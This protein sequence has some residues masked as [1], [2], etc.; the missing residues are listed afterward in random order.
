MNIIQRIIQ[1][2]AFPSFNI[3][4]LKGRT[5]ISE[6]SKELRYKVLQ[7]IF[8]ILV[9]EIDYEKM[10]QRVTDVMVEDMDFLGGVLF[11]FDKKQRE[12]IAW[13]YT[14]SRLGNIVVSWLPKSFREYRYPLD[15]K[16]NL[17]VDTFLKEKM[18]ITTRMADMISPIVSAKMSDKMQGFMGMKL[19]V[20]LPIKFHN[21]ML[22]VLFFTSVREE[23]SEEELK[24]LKTFT[25]QVAIAIQNARLFKKIQD[26]IKK[27]EINDKQQRIIFNI[28]NQLV[29]TL[30]FKEISQRAV[31]LIPRETGYFGAVLIGYDKENQLLE[32]ISRTTTSFDKQVVQII[33]ENFQDR[34]Q[35][36]ID[37]LTGK[38]TKVVESF[39]EDKIT[40]TDNFAKAFSPPLPVIMS[41][42]QQKLLNI[43]SVVSIPLKSSGNKLGIMSFI[44]VDKTP[45]EI[46][47]D[48]LNL[49]KVFANQVGIALENASLHTKVI[50]Y[51]LRLKHIAQEQKDIIDVMGHEIKTPLT[52]I[53]QEIKIHSKYTLPKEKELIEEAKSSEELSKALPL[54]F[55]TIKTTQ[56]ASSHASVLVTDM[57][58]TA[59]LDKNRFELNY[60][61]FDL[62]ETVKLNV[63]LMK[64][65]IET[66]QAKYK[67]NFE[68]PEFKEFVVEA[69][70]TRIG[71]AVYAILNNAIK[72]RDPA[73][74]E[75]K[76]DVT[77]QKNGNE[78]II[79]VTDNGIGIAPE[80]ISKLGKKFAR[81]NS[82]SNGTLKRP[83]GTGLGLFVVKGVMDHHK[84]KLIIESE[85]VGKGSKF[86]LEFPIS[87]P[88]EGLQTKV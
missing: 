77:L 3:N 1:K 33:G 8:E 37:Q 17:V 68:A 74:P 81:L 28:T 70:K 60:E 69:D 85:G 78:A 38:E 61:Q 34:Y 65:T 79:C 47:E 73:K 20:S 62:V 57:L 80:D 48:D 59:R 9:S 49:M 30:D 14:Q 22:G 42:A 40:V 39:L 16:N 58:E 10:T 2:L 13:T 43:K 82:Q 64:K 31:D 88:K 87:K 5:S 72:Y 27:L 41:N 6:T 26:Q 11:L 84:G 67:I 21:E 44:L 4:R 45:N 55:E 54:L 7:K 50:E 19:C 83:G 86:S 52:A 24:M 46:L 18:N 66:E 53:I 75:T 51:S 23:T 25:E 76:I 12:L 71:Q 35:L 15:L 56:R 63:D 32:P 36:R 29:T